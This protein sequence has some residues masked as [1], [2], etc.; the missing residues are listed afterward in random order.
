MGFISPFVEARLLCECLLI[1]CSV[2]EP[3]FWLGCLEFPMVHEFMVWERLG[4]VGIH[5]LTF[6]CILYICASTSPSIYSIII[7]IGDL[8]SLLACTLGN[9]RYGVLGFDTEQHIVRADNS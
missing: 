9:W 3:S 4:S 2:L 7:H 8:V 6:L 5:S 1:V